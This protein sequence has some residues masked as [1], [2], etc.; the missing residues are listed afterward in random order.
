MTKDILEVSIIL[1]SSEKNIIEFK[2]KKLSMNDLYKELH[3]LKD[4]KEKQDI[5]TLNNQTL[6][7]VSF[8]FDEEIIST[9]IVDSLRNKS[10][11]NTLRNEPKENNNDKFNAFEYKRS[12]SQFDSN[13]HTNTNMVTKKTENAELVRKELSALTTS[14]INNSNSNKISISSNSNIN[15]NDTSNKINNSS[16]SKSKN[17]TTSIIKNINI[18]KNDDEEDRNIS[19][20]MIS[21]KNIVSYVQ[22]DM[23]NNANY[24]KKIISNSA[25]SRLNKEID[26]SLGNNNANNVNNQITIKIENYDD[27]S[28]TSNSTSNKNSNSTLHINS[29]KNSKNNVNLTHSKSVNLNINVNNKNCSS[30]ANEDSSSIRNKKDLNIKQSASNLDT[31]IKNKLSVLN[32][33]SINPNDLSSVSNSNSTVNNLGINKRNNSSIEDIDS[34]DIK[35]IK[36]R[37]NRKGSYT[38]ILTDKVKA[39]EFLIIKRQNSISMNPHNHSHTANNTPNMSHISNT[40]KETDMIKMSNITNLLNPDK[41]DKKKPPIARKNTANFKSSN[42]I[43]NNNNCNVSTNNINNN[44]SNS[45]NIYNNYRNSNSINLNNFNLYSKQESINNNFNNISIQ[46]I[47]SN[48]NNNNN[49]IES[50]SI[51]GNHRPI[52][53]NQFSNEKTAYTLKLFSSSPQKTKDNPKKL[54]ISSN[55][56]ENSNNS[57]NNNNAINLQKQNSKNNSSNS[58]KHN[59]TVNNNYNSNYNRTNFSNV[60]FIELNY[61]DYFDYEI[62]DNFIEAIFLAGIPKTNSKLVTDSDKLLAP[63]K[64]NDCS[65]LNAYKPDILCKFPGKGRSSLELTNLSASLCF[66]HGIKVCF[67]AEDCKLSLQEDFVN[68]M[69]NECGDRFYQYNYHFYVKSDFINFQREFN[70]N[71]TRNPYLLQNVK[72]LEKHLETIS[73]LN[74][75]DF[76]YIP[77]CLVCVSKYPYS[78]QILSCLESLVS[79]IFN[80]NLNYNCSFSNNIREAQESEPISSNKNTNTNPVNN[81]TNNIKNSIIFDLNNINN[82]TNF[83]NNINTNLSNRNKTISNSIKNACISKDADTTLTTLEKFE[84]TRQNLRKISQ[85]QMILELIKHLTYEVPIPSE[86]ELLGKKLKVYVPYIEK[87]IEIYLQ[88]NELPLFSYDLIR[89]LDY[90]SVETLVIIFHLMLHER[91][92]LFVGKTA[93][94]LSL[95]LEIVRNLIYP[96]KWDNTYIPVLSEDLLKFLQSFIPYIMGIEYSLLDLAKEHIENQEDIFFVYIDKNIIKTVLNRETKKVNKKN[97]K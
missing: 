79:L 70:I 7:Q 52:L 24:S 73:K 32:N 21:M 47:Q 35:T 15:N 22:D 42:I 23:S 50:G 65:L 6:L 78:K 13:H 16:K 41:N 75:K 10:I 3:F 63:C 86:K 83:N 14:S 43:N 71:P 25:F 40:V 49:N 57:N 48:N 1:L 8:K 34:P 59:I 72:I 53:K 44:I 92:I 51:L 9:P 62:G 58:N 31:S 45:N 36:R 64:H 87:P 82:V 54:T 69:T 28:V 88:D 11:V 76:V 30:S 56:I 90:I 19:P 96:M 5:W 80:D 67:Y 91:R 18:K 20:K 29:S 77:Y 2:A 27:S 12:N 97:L 46:N 33:T 84:T 17:N 94:E 55:Y 74:A 37:M 93:K 95:V 38:N 26:S 68:V 39:D 66:T 61:E 4:K 60:E 81:D 89:I 85:S